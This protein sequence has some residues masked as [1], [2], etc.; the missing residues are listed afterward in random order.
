MKKI[1]FGGTGQKEACSVAAV[2]RSRLPLT[3]KGGK[4]KSVVPEQPLG[5]EEGLKGAHRLVNGVE[6]WCKSTRR[7]RKSSS[8]DDELLSNELPRSCFE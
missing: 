8:R 1:A 6:R 5:M 3:L 2:I 7:K 4:V